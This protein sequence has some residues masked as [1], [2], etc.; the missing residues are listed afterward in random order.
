[1]GSVL[2]VVAGRFPGCG[3]RHEEGEREGE[4]EEEVRGKKWSR[5]PGLKKEK[6]WSRSKEKAA[7]EVG[8]FSSL[9]SQ[10]VD[11]TKLF[12]SPAPINHSEEMGPLRM[13]KL[14]L[15]FLCGR[16]GGGGVIGEKVR[17]RSYW[18]EGEEEL[19]ERR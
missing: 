19:L 17:R 8:F 11:K 4:G 16:G 14:C 5:E 1:V 13:S 18:R 9:L 10:E 2:D 15:F 12:F 6:R 3:L 7:V